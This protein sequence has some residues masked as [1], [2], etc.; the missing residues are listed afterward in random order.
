LL[1]VE[2]R[3]EPIEQKDEPHGEDESRGKHGSGKAVNDVARD[4]GGEKRGKNSETEIG[5]DEAI[6]GERG[7]HAVE[8]DEAEV[9]RTAD[10]AGLRG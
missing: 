10:G 7:E 9:D 2:T 1:A 5:L 6:G 3:V 4:P 8:A